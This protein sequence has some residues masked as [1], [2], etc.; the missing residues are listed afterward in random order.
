MNWKGELLA[1]NRLGDYIHANAVKD[2]FK[3]AWA[4]INFEANHW[5]RVPE[6]EGCAYEKVCFNCAATTIQYAEP[7][8]IPIGL[9]EKT[10]CF[11]TDILGF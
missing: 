5:P 6:C 7:G 9:C 4:K 1:C 3:K 11:V 10:K 8:K 2:G